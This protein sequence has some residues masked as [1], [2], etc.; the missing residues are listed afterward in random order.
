MS[1]ADTRKFA[2]F[3]ASI[4]LASKIQ[5]MYFFAPFDDPSQPHNLSDRI[6]LIRNK[7][8]K[9]AA[10]ITYNTITT[11]SL[12]ILNA[13]A[14]VGS[15]CYLLFSKI[16]VIGNIP[17]YARGVLFPKV[18]PRRQKS[19]EIELEVQRFLNR[20][21]KA[22][23]NSY[24]KQQIREIFEGE[25][26]PQEEST[27]IEKLFEQRAFEEAN[28]LILLKFLI[29]KGKEAV[30]DEKQVLL[31]PLQ[32][33]QEKHQKELDLFST[34]KAHAK[35]ID[36]PAVESWVND[37]SEER[38]LAERTEQILGE[39]P[40]IDPDGAL[41]GECLNDVNL[42]AAGHLQNRLDQHLKDLTLRQERAEQAFHPLLE[43][44]YYSLLAQRLSL[45]VDELRWQRNHDH[46]EG[47]NRVVSQSLRHIHETL[48]TRYRG[49]DIPCPIPLPR[50]DADIDAFFRD[51]ENALQGLHERELRHFEQNPA[52]AIQGTLIQDMQRRILSAIDNPYR[53]ECLSIQTSKER[54][55][56]RN[57][58][59]TENIFL[60]CLKQ[61]PD[62]QQLVR[63]M[64]RRS[65]SEEDC[66]LHI[67]MHPK[68]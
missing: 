23:I 54:K 53:R 55:A 61:T 30:L 35:R 10:Q 38:Y 14:R 59:I 67:I 20:I 45:Y 5:H 32:K 43:L 36:A 37:R 46:I 3:S 21:L 50:E 33:L 22:P 57:R 8:C 62:G 7:H 40:D 60:F 65:N 18:T 2:F 26:S 34:L 27:F 41:W 52:Y 17:S 64:D 13:C 12:G 6:A 1:F 28:H 19:E 16:Q 44:E 58:V 39:L 51:A 49:L 25:F 63:L 56:R 4:L 11:I 42:E 68:I 31:T 48:Q 47:F 29:K 24:Q 9:A 15:A 66:H